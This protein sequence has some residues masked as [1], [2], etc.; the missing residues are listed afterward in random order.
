MVVADIQLGYQHGKYTTV[1]WVSCRNGATGLFEAGSTETTDDSLVACRIDGL[2][3]S[4]KVS[5]MRS[6]LDSLVVTGTVT[7]SGQNHF[8]DIVGERN[9]NNCT[10]GQ[11]SI[12]S[13]FRS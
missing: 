11:W 10:I 6:V 7:A 12:G 1:R 8:L 5:S 3:G 13:L 2:N 4:L 9:H